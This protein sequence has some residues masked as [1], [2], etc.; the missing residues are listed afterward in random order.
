MKDLKPIIFKYILIV[1][2]LLLVSCSLN[3]NNT[4]SSNSN[5]QEELIS[6]FQN[7]PMQ[8]HPGVYW[9]F[10][11]GNLNKEEMTKDLI[12]MKEKGISH[13]VFL[14]VNVGIPRGKV[15]FM[16]EEWLNLFAHAEKKARELDIAITLGV[17][18]GWTGSGG[19]W[20][21]GEESM[22]HMVANDT[23]VQ[24]GRLVNIKLP[25]PEANKPFFGLS[26]F[27]PELEKRWEK[28]YEDIVVLAFPNKNT[29]KRI[30]NLER[31]SLVYRYPFTSDSR[32]IPFIPKTTN[33]EDK[34]IS[35]SQV[36]DITDK[37][38]TSGN[39]KWNAPEG[40]WV[41][42]R[43]VARNNGAVT[44]PAPLPGVGFE[45]NK[46]DT[47]G[48]KKHLDQF[49]GKILDKIKPLNT[50]GKGGLKMLHM[51]SWEMGAQNWTQNFETEFEKR[52]GY[53]PKPYYPAYAGFIVENRDVTER[54]L[55]D[56]RITSQELILENHAGYLK[57]YAN[58]LG[59]GL[60]IEPYDMN[61]TSDLLL[62]AVADVPMAEFWTDTFD[63]HY[64]VIQASSIAHVNGK[65]ILPS[66]AF[67]SGREEKMK[68]HPA[69]L[70]NIGDWALAGGVNRIVF[71]T[72]AHKPL[73]DSLRPGMTM[74]PYGVHWDRGQTWWPYV[75]KYHEYLAKSS[76]LL[77]QGQAVSDI[78]FLTPEG[79]PHV[80]EAPPSALAGKG[81]LKDKKEYSFDGVAPKTL[82]E[83][84]SVVDGKISF[85]EATNYELLVLPNMEYM[86]PELLAFIE[87]LIINGA[88]VIGNP[89]TKSP[90][91]MDYPEAD[92]EVNK[93]SKKI[94][95]AT[96]APNE[97]SSRKY[98]EGKIY[99]GGELTKKE[100][101]TLYPSYG[102]I[103]KVLKDLKIE[104][105]FVGDEKLRYIHRK[106]K[107]T[108]IYFLSN[109]LDEKISI[110]AN[111]RVAGKKPSLWHSDSGR[112][113]NLP[114]YKDNDKTTEIPL[115]FEPHESY[116][117]IFSKEE[118]IEEK[119]DEN[120]YDLETLLTI[121]GKWEVNFDPKWGGSEKVVFKQLTDWSKHKDEGIKYYSGQAK[122]STKFNLQKDK[123]NKNTPLILSLG[124]VKVIAEVTLNDKKVGTV[125]TEP[126]QIDISEFIKDGENTLE[127]VVANQWSNRLIGDEQYK[128]DGIVDEEWPDW[129]IENKAR[130]SKR[131]TLV[132]YP[133][134]KA[135]DPLQPSG[136]IGPVKILN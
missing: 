89:Y 76:Y 10:M 114:N 121:D 107:G 135:N 47:I 86:R 103:T 36:I 20:V 102:E 21:K 52:R 51:D 131:Y 26:A 126:W 2:A 133:F 127:I 117:V 15:D 122:Y 24:G 45:S 6:N 72:F 59:L 67:T 37:M 90:S 53:D 106:E 92:E 7:P 120:F 109:T 46:F 55:W 11:D 87:K 35:I 56:L 62:G 123:I 16:S 44:R 64:A 128:N 91:L 119:P 65:K 88:K 78:L 79:V 108:D 77:Q 125:W 73:G 28:F 8:A 112:I 71:H 116:F 40:D 25:V 66:E 94:W 9:Y 5:L 96:K 33:L 93:L 84:A 83:K 104:P 61:P 12:S 74:G 18:P 43:F 22:K 39:L 105:D 136:L 111:F 63:A 110:N 99:F 98:G 27:T 41:I 54:F 50:N 32:S 1:S 29:D 115:I 57:Q 81:W 85:P 130:P 19:P 70:K 49:L 17:G 4:E 23:L 14:E 101:Q 58:D 118:F 75:K 68:H 80:F 34:G 132:T 97:F 30:D 82:M 38:D 13:L 124:D 60:S 134:Y 31:K 48:V 69:S 129:L 95:G 100:E 113:I 3:S 42:M